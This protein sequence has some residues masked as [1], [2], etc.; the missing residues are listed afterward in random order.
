MG[1]V[2][3]RIEQL[4]KLG[5]FGGAE[6]HHPAVAVR[7]AIDRGRIAVQRAV[8]SRTLPVTGLNNSDTALTASM[9][10]NA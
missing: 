9:V 4:T 5:G 7:I 8:S 1:L 3:G 6:P 10:P 2:G